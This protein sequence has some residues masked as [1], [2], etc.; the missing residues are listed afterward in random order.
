MCEKVKCSKRNGRISTFCKHEQFGILW[1][2][3]EDKK[4]KK[5][6][7]LAMLLAAAMAAGT[8][9]IS[10]AAEEAP[11]VEIS[12]MS[13]HGED[14][15]T[16]FYDGMKYA[17]DEYTKL[18]PNVTFNYIMQPY[19]GYMDLLDTQYIAGTAADLVYMQ[20][21][22]INAFADKGVL[23]PL[24]DFMYGE[25]PYAEG[26]RW[27]DT[28]TG[29]ESSFLSSKTSNSMGSIMFVPS[30]SN[31]GLNV[32][33]PFF[34]NKTLFEKAGISE[35][36][37]TYTE[38]IA[39]LQQLKDAGITPLASDYERG[40]SWMVG[41]LTD[42]FGEHYTDQFFDEKYNGSDK[43]TL[44]DDKDNIIFANDMLK[45]DDDILVQMSETLYEISQ[46]WQDGWTGATINDA[47]NLFLMQ[48]VAIIQDGNWAYNSYVDMVTD[49]EW[50]VIA[51][52]MV[53]KE[54]SE[55]ALE[56]F[57]KPSGN[58]DSGYCLSGKL[59]EDPE[60]LAVII[61]F[62]QFL[63]SKD[64][65]QGYVEAAVS[66]S[67][68][69]GV[70]QPEELQ[71]FLFDTEKC[72]YEQPIGSHYIDWGDSGIWIGLAEDFLAGKMDV[73][74]FNQK[75]LDNSK[76]TAVNNCYDK[77]DTLPGL[78]EEAE[79]K[80]AELQEEQA[81]EDVIKAQQDSLDLLKLKLEMYEQYCSDL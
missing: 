47:K 71:P 31:P 50:G 22:M 64:I 75:V 17:M 16:K 14:S 52:P 19:D 45:A 73:V 23:L 13:W 7:C 54:T 25:T 42:Q 28:F 29:G 5:R 8:L 49:F 77:L 66:F 62:V 51:I 35:L 53:T 67:P 55:Y 43:V 32:G 18:Y 81:A 44:K 9:P 39:C 76:M 41:T 24:D 6:K 70:E 30:D 4:V 69:D 79:A 61:D 74:T 12:I 34:Y 40:L 80:L 57:K 56:G 2:K 10:A 36:P 38:F 65:Q 68:V 46:Y 78:I 3:Q 59:A 1:K 37:T 58:M 21:H 27:I 33:Q 15:D 26:Q 72:L 48:E 20:P 11:E 63:T 60:R